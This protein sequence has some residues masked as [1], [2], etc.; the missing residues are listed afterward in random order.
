MA[1]NCPV[2]KSRVLNGST[3]SRRILKASAEGGGLSRAFV[4]L[5]RHSSTHITSSSETNLFRLSTIGS[6]LTRISLGPVDP[7]SRRRVRGSSLLSA[8]MDGRDAPP[9]FIRSPARDEKDSVRLKGKSTASPARRRLLTSS[10]L[11]FLVSLPSSQQGRLHCSPKSSIRI[12]RCPCCTFGR[13]FQ[14]S[15]SFSLLSLLVLPLVLRVEILEVLEAELPM[16]PMLAVRT[17]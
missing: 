17:I 9:L 2:P 7:S 4:G 16:L 3:R 1:L 12:Y 6:E 14:M 11:F 13:G 8:F 15:F 10:C 5:L